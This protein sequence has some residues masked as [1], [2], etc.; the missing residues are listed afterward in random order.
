[1]WLS[2]PFAIRYWHCTSDISPWPWPWRFGLGQKLKAKILADYNVHHELPSTRVNYISR[3]TYLTHLRTCQWWVMLL[4]CA[5]ILVRVLEKTGFHYFIFHRKPLHW[6][7]HGLRLRLECSGLV[8]VTALCMLCFC[9]LLIYLHGLL[10]NVPV[11]TIVRCTYK[12]K[13]VL[14]DFIYWLT[15]LYWLCI[16]VLVL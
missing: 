2:V 11:K 3:S 14:I 13:T 4:N 7:G 9:L 16:S 5:C 10:F 12:F 15:N 6:D 1:M 8:N